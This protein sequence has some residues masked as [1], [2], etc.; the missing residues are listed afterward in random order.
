MGRLHGEGCTQRQR[1]E[2]TVSGKAWQ[3]QNWGNGKGRAMLRGELPIW[4][5][6]GY[7]GEESEEKSESRPCRAVSAGRGG[8]VP[9]LL[10][11][12][13]SEQVWDLMKPCVDAALKKG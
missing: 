2:N 6:C 13:I 11:P 10:G 12:G 5:K 3:E 4:L 8:P 7:R 1:V 9:Y